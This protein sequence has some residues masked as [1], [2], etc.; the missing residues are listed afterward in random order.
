MTDPFNNIFYQI[1]PRWNSLVLELL[2][3]RKRLPAIDY[4]QCSAE[5]RI[6]VSKDDWSVWKKSKTGKRS[7]LDL[8]KAH[9][10]PQW[11]F[12]L[13][14]RN[15]HKSYFGVTA[16]QKSSCRYLNSVCKA[17]EHPNYMEKSICDANPYAVTTSM[18]YS[19]QTKQQGTAKVAKKLRRCS[20]ITT[21]EFQNQSNDLEIINAMGNVIVDEFV[22]TVLLSYLKLQRF[23][24]QFSYFL[25]TKI[26][27]T[28]YIDLIKQHAVR[29]FSLIIFNIHWESYRAGINEKQ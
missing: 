22:V 18:H 8:V 25:L 10:N 4:L 16:W 24:A 23:G 2:N 6:V 27:S 15:K 20:Q 14:V 17:H 11:T 21:F 29:Y 5:N 28:F 7:R 19:R 3:N 1:S 12:H 26:I 13:A 9:Q